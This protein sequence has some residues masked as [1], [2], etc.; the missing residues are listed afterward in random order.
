MNTTP[1]AQM[2]A[3]LEKIN[4]PSREIKVYGSQI[5]VECLSESAAKNWA[6]GLAQFATVRGIVQSVAYAKSDAGSTSMIRKTIPVWRTYATV[7]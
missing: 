7:Q 2:K 4:L 3:L 1:Q 5:T 6:C